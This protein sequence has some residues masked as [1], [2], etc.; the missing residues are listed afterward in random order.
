MLIMGCAK[1]RTGKPESKKSSRNREASSQGRE[2]EKSKSSVST[3]S[4]NALS[5]ETTAQAEEKKAALAVLKAYLDAVIAGGDETNWDLSSEAA[6]ASVLKQLAA[7]EQDKEHFLAMFRE[8]VAHE[9]LTSYTIK[10]VDLYDDHIQ[11]VL[12]TERKNVAEAPTS[13]EPK[14]YTSTDTFKLIEENGRWKVD[15]VTGGAFKPF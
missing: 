13:T 12:L 6:H 7:E 1:S 14:I 15:W 11:V 4:E 3:G 8:G 5:G 9:Q 10:A 2:S